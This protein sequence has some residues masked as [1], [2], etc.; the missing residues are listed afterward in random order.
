MREPQSGYRAAS[1]TIF[2]SLR[3]AP[4]DGTGSASAWYSVRKMIL[5][6]TLDGS[7]DDAGLAIEVLTMHE[8]EV[9]QTVPAGC[10]STP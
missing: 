5:Q 9:K 2:A 8:R 1:G 7:T 6:Q 4:K 3:D 10:W